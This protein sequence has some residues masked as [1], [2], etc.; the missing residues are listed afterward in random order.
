MGVATKRMHH[1]LQT[2]GDLRD[3]HGQTIGT[4]GEVGEVWKTCK[5]CVTHEN[6]KGLAVLEVLC[7]SAMAGR[8]VNRTTKITG[9]FGYSVAG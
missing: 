8:F 1:K 2:L 9:R 7:R 4:S 5:I 6:V 3:A